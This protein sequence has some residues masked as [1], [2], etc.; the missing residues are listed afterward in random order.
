HYYQYQVILKPS[1]A[2]SQGVYL[3]S[4]KSFGVDPLD[5][6]IRFVED[7]WESPTLGASGLGW[8]VWAD[9]QEV[10]Q[11]TYFQQCGGI[12][13]RPVSVEHAYGLE[14]VKGVTYRQ[15]RHHDEVEYSK[16]NFEQANAELGF[17][18]FTSFEAECK[19]LL[20]VGLVLPAYEHVLKCSHTFNVLD[21]RGAIGVTE[22]Q[23]Y[24]GRVRG[25]ARLCAAAYLAERERL[26]FPMLPQPLATAT[27]EVSR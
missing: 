18:L 4:L 3:E 9:G 27:P 1:P 12:E 8:E 25:L 16:F 10:T 2:D 7:D 15:V 14:W 24:I 22:R 13:C 17:Q 19:R 5:H 23:R 6:D 26:G 20:E 11:F 21:A